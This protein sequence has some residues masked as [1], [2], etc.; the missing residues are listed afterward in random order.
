MKK[1][2]LFSLILLPI[3]IL[4]YGSSVLSGLTN[5]TIKFDNVTK[6]YGDADF[7]PATATS[8]LSVIYLS[9][10]TAVA[11]VV[12]GGKKIRIVGVG[13]A[14]ITATQ[15][16]NGTY[17]AAPNVKKKLTVNK[18]SQSV[19]FPQP[20]DFPFGSPDYD[21]G[22]TASTGLP[23]TIT[24]SNPE[25]ITIVNGKLRFVGVGQALITA[26]QAGNAYYKRSPDANRWVTVGK[27]DQT[28]TFSNITKT[29]KDPDFNPGA[30][31]SSGLS[32]TY[33]TGNPSVAIPSFDGIKIVGAGSTTITATQAGNSIF[34]P[35]TATVTLTVERAVQ[36]ISF[37]IINPVNYGFPDFNP[38]ATSDSY[39]T[40]IY[41]SDNSSVAT[42]VNNM[43]HIV[44]TG[45]ANITASQPGN[46][47][48]K[49]A[50]NVTREL[51]VNKASQSI[52]FD[53][54][55]SRNYNDPDFSPDA[56]SSSGLAITYS[57]SN[58]SVATI[59]AGKIHITGVGTTTISANQGGNSNYSPALTVSQN[60]TV[61]KSAQTISFNSLIEKAIG[62]P[63]F[64]L[65]ASSSSGLSISYT[66]DN[67][68]V[69]TVSNGV[70]HIVGTGVANITAKQG[71]NTFYMPASDVT[72]Q[73]KVKN[74]FQTITFGTLPA[75]T[76]GDADFA[77]LATSSSG[78]PVTYFSDNSNV[79]TI[80]GNMVKIT[81]AG[82]ANIFAMQAGDD[83][84]AEAVPVPQ[85]L[86]V[87][88]ASQI[89]TF[90]PIP[91][92]SYNN[93]SFVPYAVSSSGL[94][95]DFSSSNPLVAIIIG[96]HIYITGVGS[97]V[98]TAT[99]N[100]S[101]NYLSASAVSQTLTVN[102]A[103]Q[104]ITFNA[105]P[106]KVYG[107]PDFVLN[108]E[109]TSG[110]QI[111][112]SVNNPSVATISNNRVHITGTGT[113]VI[114][115]SQSGSTDFYSADS[116]S[117]VLVVNKAT[118]TI[119]FPELA[120]VNYG[121]PGFQLSASSSA[122]LEMNYSSSNSNVATINNG[123]VQV[124]NAGSAYITASQS[125]N[126]YY[127]A[128]TPISQL[129]VVNKQS[130]VIVFDSIPEKTYGDSDFDA[131]AI[132]SSN[133]PVSYI[134]DN[135][136]VAT[137]K[138]GK[139]HIVGAGTTTITAKQ[140]GNNNYSASTENIAR[141][142]VVKKAVLTVTPQKA[143][144]KYL[145]ADPPFT[146]TYNGFVNLESSDV[147]DVLPVI[148]TNAENSSLP[149]MYDLTCSGGTDNN[150]TFNYQK[151]ILLVL[152]TTPLKP[153]KPEGNT[154]ICINPEVQN[155]K[156]SGSVFGATYIWTVVP[157]NAGKVTANGKTI[158][159]DYNDDFTGRVAIAVKSQ[160]NQGIGA[161]SDT[162]FVDIL[163]VPVMP[164]I[165]YRGTYCSTNGYG[166]SIKI[167]NSLENYGYQLFSDDKTIGEVL[168]GNGG[169]IGW[170][171]LREG[172]YSI[173]ETVCST[174]MAQGL[175]ITKV[176]PSS[177]KPQLEVKW[178]DVIICINP[179]DSIE[180]YRWYKN[181]EYLSAETKQ[182]IWTQKQEGYYSV[183][184]TDITGCVFSSDSIWIDRQ[185]SGRIYPNPNNGNFKLTFSS[186]EMGR[187]I[188]RISSINSLPVKV[189]TFDKEE[190]LFE[191]EISIPELITGV[192]YI[193]V[194]LKDERVF[195]EKFIR[196]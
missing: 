102:K 114:T 177:G 154:K 64:A 143:S 19:T 73:L 76:Y 49:P 105:I 190:E 164:E 158:S 20:P 131:G 167:L 28:I 112:Y 159:I 166:D 88:K 79:A 141:T 45:K 136:N 75:K 179:G 24:S 121:S 168:I 145:E 162:L 106:S 176:D 33:T 86:T 23:V 193:E 122:G 173:L 165:S 65:T 137:I 156:T 123:F 181:G 67:P 15:P 31:V 5:Q 32:L 94:G 60:F 66:C 34:N 196:E 148:T 35:A 10:N 184:T 174:V 54:I 40:V 80:T 55:Q 12:D 25:I 110:L 172:N 11:I 115:A 153:A 163:G 95:V 8:G 169:E 134:I 78:L 36:N 147:I 48:F 100:G 21:P 22:A 104:T 89:I 47:N 146:A 87:S 46:V 2:S 93:D 135:P 39:L 124:M 92:K 56:Y 138:N 116:R 9:N 62:Q 1:L 51:T 42:I 130:Q 195:Y 117:Q 151:G 103:A 186:P 125:G 128:A 191:K 7:S 189:F 63:D 4:I 72:Q 52:T 16:G 127:N 58:S 53:L 26:Y 101:S 149:G 96:G 109:S 140:N 161:T 83:D 192:Y 187:L 57:S 175:E 160:N 68:A 183:K 98:I 29:Y 50:V 182:Y 91:T 74:S 99:Q 90:P 133:L 61:S 107:D 108:A 6:T 27:A 43:I 38:G 150:Y 14:E 82:V 142:L 71:G 17:A 77:L 152:G 44:G 111:N 30:V 144:R 13:T 118:Q 119:D 139:V 120:A 37:P 157:D 194:Q 155:Y 18:A 171:D 59:V 70:V 185:A 180:D 178:N 41:A 84:F 126:Q 81:G 97:S 132:A 170:G 85:Q 188:V 113:C 69:A 129:L 3:N